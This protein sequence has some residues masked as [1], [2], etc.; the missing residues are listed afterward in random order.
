MKQLEELEAKVL[1]LIGRNQDL[2]SQLDAANKEIERLGAQNKQFESSFLNQSSATQVLVQEKA[3]LLSGIED[4]LNSI[5][6]IE[7][8]R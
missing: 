5:N 1:H 2:R 3:A 4:L 6:T 7:N 8:P